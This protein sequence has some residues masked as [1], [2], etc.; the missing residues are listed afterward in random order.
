MLVCLAVN[1]PMHVRHIARII[2][3]D[4]HKTYD[5]VER[6]IES[7]LVI[8]RFH[9]GGRKYVYLN[10]KLPVYRSLLK[11]LLKLDEHWPVERVEKSVAR[12]YMPFDDDM[13]PARMDNVFQSPIRSRVLTFI[14]ASGL[15][16]MTRIVAVTQLGSVSVL[17]AVNHW[18]REGIV[19]TKMV[20]NHRMVTLNPQFEA[21]KEL[22]AFLRVM[23]SRLPEYRGLRKVV[24]KR[25]KPINKRLLGRS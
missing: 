9:E 19:K 18:E 25:M 13:A 20:K 2:E 12:W 23:V 8:K 24:H 16:D 4:S 7:G 15:T 17:Y 6:L 5:M 1:G 22:A 14:A 3:S 21:A 11:L 10:R